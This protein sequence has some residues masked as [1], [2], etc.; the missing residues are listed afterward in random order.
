M[1]I[2]EGIERIATT[3]IDRDLTTSNK[4]DAMLDFMGYIHAYTCHLAVL[5]RCHLVI[6]N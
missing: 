2:Q 1:G 3:F 4:S 5:S 6:G